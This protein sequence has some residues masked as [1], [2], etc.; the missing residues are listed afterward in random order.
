MLYF[1]FLILFGL[2]YWNQQGKR[3]NISII[4]IG[5][6]VYVLFFLLIVPGH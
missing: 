6:V 1:I 4:N 3:L 5:L 2:A